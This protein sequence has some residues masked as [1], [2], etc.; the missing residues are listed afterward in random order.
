MGQV[1]DIVLRYS[2][3]GMEKMRQFLPDDF[4]MRAAR[5]ILSWPRGRVIVTTGFHVNGAPE[6]DGPV[7]AAVIAGVLYSLGYVPLIVSEAA[8][9]EFFAD[10]SFAT[11][12]VDPRFSCDDAC[13]M[14][15]RIEP[16]GLI[17]IERCGR[18]NGGDY[19][20]MRG[21]SVFEHTAELDWLFLL[22]AGVVPSVGVGDGGNEIG[23]GAIAGHI[24]DQLGLS[25]CVTPVDNLVIATVSN[26][27]AYGIA[28]CLAKLAR[29]NLLPTPTAQREFLTSILS[30]GAVD[31][32]NGEGTL[33]VDGFP[34][35]VGE[36]VMRDL[37]IWSLGDERLSYV[38]VGRVV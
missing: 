15:D 10:R 29:K 34:A 33:S 16:V 32:I 12:V 19:A 9:C 14:L 27:G 23:M 6:T 2:N 5:N 4:C 13:K 25:P 1:E 18:N 31:G 17:S 24:S 7:G 36:G 8:C 38:S 26:W 11:E 28:A 35:E 22:S 21:A 3:R 20:N 37:K 30:K